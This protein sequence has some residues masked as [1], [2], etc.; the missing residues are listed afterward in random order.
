MVLMRGTLKAMPKGLSL[1]P[2]SHTVEG[3]NQLPQVVLR[4]PCVS[5]GT[6]HTH[7]H[8]LLKSV[9]KKQ[10]WGLYSSPLLVS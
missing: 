7:I 4:P 9:G 6:Y 5:C 8:M 1:I 10:R 3:K 2:G